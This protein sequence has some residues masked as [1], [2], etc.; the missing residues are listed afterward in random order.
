[1]HNS[2]QGPMSLAPFRKCAVFQKHHL[3]SLSHTIHDRIVLKYYYVAHMNDRNLEN[4][5]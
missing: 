3:F 1:M 5:S 2:M 4:R